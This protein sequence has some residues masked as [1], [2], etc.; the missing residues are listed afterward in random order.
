LYE[1]GDFIH[2]RGD[3]R[4]WA[5]G[6]ETRSGSLDSMKDAL[7]RDLFYGQWAE[8]HLTK[9]WQETG[10]TDGTITVFDDGSARLAIYSA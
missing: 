6:A 8:R 3:C 7:A 9:S 10:L 5:G 2:V 4:Y 1:N